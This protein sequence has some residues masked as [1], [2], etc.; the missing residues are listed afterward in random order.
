MSAR[1]VPARADRRSID[2]AD[3]TAVVNTGDDTEIHG[4]AISPDLDTIIYTLAG[5]STRAGL[6]P[7]GET[8]QAMDAL[9][10]YAGARPAGSAAATWFN[11]GDRTWRPTC[12]ARPAGRGRPPT[13]VTDEIATGVGRR[14]PAPAR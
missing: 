5:R 3:R 8:W 12:T 9:D 4:L 2:P 14:R 7:G 13:E 1:P 6:G 11:L 10:R